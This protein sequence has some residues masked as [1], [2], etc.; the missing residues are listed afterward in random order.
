MFAPL[1]EIVQSLP[2]EQRRRWERL[3]MCSDRRDISA[4]P[5]VYSHP[6]TGRDTLCLHLGKRRWPARR[7]HSSR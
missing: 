4:K 5:L 2:E 3:S 7:A 1:D 6:L